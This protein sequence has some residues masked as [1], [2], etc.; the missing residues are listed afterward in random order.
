MLSAVLV[1]RL[2]A[3]LTAQSI[4]SADQDPERAVSEVLSQLEPFFEARP[5]GAV[6][7][8]ATS[9][10]TTVLEKLSREISQRGKTRSV[11][12]CTAANVVSG[13]ADPAPTAGISGLCLAGELET[14]P[15]MI[16]RLRGRSLEIG[17]EIGRRAAIAGDDSTTV[18]LFA[19]SYN[20]A[21]DELLIGFQD[22][23][24][25]IPIIGAGASEDGASGR[26][27]VM[28]SDCVNED[29]VAGLVVRGMSVATLRTPVFTPVEPWWRVTRAEANRVYELDD[30][31]ALAT[32]MKA[33]PPS[34][35]DDPSAT[36]SFLQLALADDRE[37]GDPLLRPVIGSS[38]PDQCLDV[39]D[40]VVEGTR[41][42]VAVQDPAAA[43]TR[44]TAE[45]GRLGGEES[46]AGLLYFHSALRG[47]PLYG[48]PGLDVAYLRQN[49]ADVGVAGFASYLTLSPLCGRNRF[50]QFSGLV[51]GLAPAAPISDEHRE[52]RRAESS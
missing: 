47:E 28:A 9:A 43:R 29:A 44:F 36:L 16:P 49:F 22:T 46:P 3:V 21:P 32:L 10:Y 39:G 19:D 17:R 2:V 48:H 52:G 41:L 8:F 24:G 13:A 45:L 11:L 30:A 27:E 7:L 1:G 26:T 50:H 12:A 6:V 15:F 20:L 35:Q 33:L 34:L 23:A 40:A 25:E 38:E 4:S 42:A 18:L 14:E 31:P 5:G 51:V 37:S